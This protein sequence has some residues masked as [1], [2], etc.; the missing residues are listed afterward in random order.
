MTFADPWLRNALT[1]TLWSSR[2]GPQKV[3]TPV[4]THQ[5][6][7]WREKTNTTLHCLSRE[8]CVV[9]SVFCSGRTTQVNTY[10]SGMAIYRCILLLYIYF[11]FCN[12]SGMSTLIKLHWFSV[13][14]RKQLGYRQ[15]WYQLFGMR[16]T[17]GIQK[18]RGYQHWRDA[19]SWNCTSRAYQIWNQR[20]Q[21]QT[22]TWN[23]IRVISRSSKSYWKYQSS[24]ARSASTATVNSE[25]FFSH[26]GIFD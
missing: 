18:L 22:A 21:N 8:E 14:F 7:R 11:S 20:R 19:F 6:Q 15:E 4:S 12:H 26:S 5:I 3:P 13:I 10:A 23:Q 25:N 9:S 1:N 24:E 16:I 2:R 17:G